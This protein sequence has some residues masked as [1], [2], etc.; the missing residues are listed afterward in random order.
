MQPSRELF[1][2]ILFCHSK[3]KKKRKEKKSR[4]SLQKKFP[5]PLILVCS[6]C[7]NP[8]S[9][10]K[11]F[12][13]FP[14]FFKEYHNPQVKINKIVTRQSVNDHPSL[15]GLISRTYSLIILKTWCFIFLNNFCLIFFKTCISRYFSGTFSNWRC[16]NY[17][18]CI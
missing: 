17:W 15:S 14:S 9:K 10:S 8:S 13:L 6:R 16:S 5:L 4:Q 18:Q 3:K 2:A 1:Q 11:P 7:L 12:I